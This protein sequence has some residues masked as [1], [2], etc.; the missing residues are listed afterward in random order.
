MSYGSDGEEGTKDESDD[1][2]GT[3]SY[4]GDGGEGGEG[5]D[6]EDMPK[7]AADNMRLFDFFCK[8]A[9]QYANGVRDVVFQNMVDGYV[10]N[11]EDE[12]ALRG[13]VLL[14]Q[15]CEAGAARGPEDASAIL[16]KQAMEDP[17]SVM[18]EEVV[19][20]AD[21]LDQ[22]AGMLE[23]AGVEPEDVEQAQA[24][25]QE[26]LESGASPEDLEIAMSELV[27]EAMAP[28]G[29]P[30]EKIACD[31]RQRAAIENVK[32]YMLQKNAAAI[33]VVTSLKG[34]TPQKS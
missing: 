17:A 33:K 2:S 14:K 10:K 15:A 34:K 7:E 4:D 32:R 25:V 11:A 20:Q 31:F 9:S 24:V 27:D 29:A 26:L 13:S 6:Y 30:V 22:A 8:Q 21:E 18:P 28:E 23:E 5:P 1:T 19:S 12:Q 3:D 16:Y